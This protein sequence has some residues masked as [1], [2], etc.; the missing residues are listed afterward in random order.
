MIMGA[1]MAVRLRPSATNQ[2]FKAMTNLFKAYRNWR[3]KR[4]D[5]KLRLLSLQ[6]AHGCGGRLY[7]VLS[8]THVFYLYLKYG[9]N[10]DGVEVGE[11][12]KRVGEEIPGFKVPDK[13][14]K[15]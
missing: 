1:P 12:F 5:A 7:D 13:P 10:K 6:F 14:L 11:I 4:R 2:N 8:H 3:E 9:F 15:P